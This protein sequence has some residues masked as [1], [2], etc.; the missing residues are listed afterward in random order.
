MVVF[1]GCCSRVNTHAIPVMSVDVDVY[2]FF[3]FFYGAELIS[4]FTCIDWFN[5]EMHAAP[6]NRVRSVVG[7]KYPIICAS[8]GSLIGQFIAYSL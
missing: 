7:A 4:F 5:S 1:V 6:H 3:Y 2:F 8:L